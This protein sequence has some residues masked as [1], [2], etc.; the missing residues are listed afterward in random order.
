MPSIILELRLA[1][2][3]FLREPGFSVPAVTTLAVGIGIAAS[4]FALI[5]GILIRPLPYPDPGRLVSIRHVAPGIEITRDGMSPGMWVHYRDGNR[6]FEA[7]S[8][9]ETTSYTFTGD[10][11]GERIRTGLVKPGLFDVLDVT[12]LLGRLPSL[13]D[14]NYD[15][16]TASGTFGGLISHDLWVRRYAADPSVIGRVI[17]V[18]GEPTVEVVGVAPE[19]FSFPDPQT[20]AWFVIPAEPWSDVAAVRQGMYLESIARL[21]PGVTVEE[22]EADLERLVALLPERFADVTEASLRE[23]GLRPMVRP[24]KEEVVADVRPTLLLVMGSGA[25]LLLVTCANVANLLLLRTHGRRLGLGVARALGASEWNVAR[26]L[27]IESLLLTVSGSL[28]GLGLADLATATRFGFEPHQLPRLGEVGVGAPVVA[29]V[30]A[31]ALLSAVF[32][33]AVCFFSTRRQVAGPA[34]SSMRSRSATDGHEG[35]TGR[36]LLVAA[37]MAMAL[38]LLVG[39]GLMARTYWHLQRADLGFES[40]DRLSFRLSTGYLGLDAGYGDMADLHD[41][42]LQRLRAVPGVEAVEAGSIAVFPLVLPEAIDFQPIVPAEGFER[43]G[44]PEPQALVGYAT[45]G[46]FDAMGIPLLSGRRFETRD[47]SLDAPGVIVSRSLADALFGDTEPLGRSLRFADFPRWSS[48]TVVGIVGDVPGRTVRE[49]ASRAIYFPLVHPAAADV[50]AAGVYRYRP[51]DE[52]YVIRTARDVAS[53]VPELRSAAQEVDPRLPLLDLTPVDEIV[54]EA[55]ARERV[56]MRVLMVSGA[57]ALFLGVVGVYG[58]LGY[59]VR[60][61]TAELG[62]RLAL[63]AS[64]KEVTRQIVAQGAALSTAG[65]VAGIAAALLLTRFMGALLY[66]TSPTDPLTFTATALLLMAVSLAASYLPARRASRIDPAQAL[67]GE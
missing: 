61:R 13:A 2:R 30:A 21:R 41:R 65:I 23:T 42:V 24:Y 35:Q 32:M 43:I 6:V 1:G 26:Q 64:P 50:V 40:R 49:G 37:Q 15:F 16:D 20:E 60:R 57:A 5:E 12:P 66:R 59:A 48:L 62:I 22:A 8:A 33:A 63:G 67:R 10:G 31:L 11:E 9:Y 28:L 3:R 14:W 38:T 34:L 19:G 18:D 39:S 58:V 55:A 54:G 51:D 47:A 46:Y 45:S 53:I 52:R 27:L 17:T 29:L 7:V 25:F 44:T 56:V 4:A 36:R